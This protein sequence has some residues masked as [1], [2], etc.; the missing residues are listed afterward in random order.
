MTVHARILAY[1]AD[2]AVP[3]RTLH[4]EA[5]LTS[6]ASARA[7]GEPL[8]IGAKAIVLKVGDAFHLF[9]LSAAC[10]L[11]A[12]KIKRFFKVKKVRFAT[13][14]ELAARTGLVPG[15]VPPF[16]PPILDL[17]L[18]LDPSVTAND[19]VAFNA[20]SLTDSIL[21]ATPHYLKVA[22][23]TLLDFA[24]DADEAEVRNVK[25]E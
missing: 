9:V 23:A 14:A 12:K 2:Q 7:R 19:R 3:F 17:D 20:G 8:A 25:K 6:E 24:R 16:G 4:H 10:K 13:P 18:Y 22:G 11:D 15:A 1:L 21:L 5:T